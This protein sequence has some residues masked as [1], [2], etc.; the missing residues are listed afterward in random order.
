MAPSPVVTMA[1]ILVVEDEPDIA[2]GLQEDLTRHG[3]L[4][5]IARDGDSA[6]H[7]GQKEGWDVIILD[8]MLPFRDGLEVCR[9]LRRRRI[10]T[11]VIMLSAR[12][13]EAEKILGLEVGADDYVTKPFSPAELRARIKAVLR[14]FDDEGEGIAR[15]GNCEID[16][17][18]AEIR[19][20]GTPVDVTA[21]ELRLLSALIRAR[22]RVLTREQLIRQAWGETTYVG[23]RVVDTHILNLRKKIEPV[24]GQ[25]RF[26][27]SVRGLGYRLEIET[28]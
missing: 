6:L 12:T 15:I 7:M 21:L 3:H 18:R 10:R 14:R 25:P 5:E 28:P 8:V 2:M 16:F 19:R 27:K 22:G 26:L 23:D 24:A 13:H 4:V 17:E 11:P 20:G 1:R 9:E